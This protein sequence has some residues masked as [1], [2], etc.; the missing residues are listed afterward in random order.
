MSRFTSVCLASSNNRY[1][2]YSETVFTSR[3][4]FTPGRARPNK[5]KPASLQYP[6]RQQPLNKIRV[7][8]YSIISGVYMCC[9]LLRVLDMCGAERH[10]IAQVRNYA[11]TNPKR[12]RLLHMHALNLTWEPMDC[13]P[14]EISELIER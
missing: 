14:T 7:V 10:S 3:V 1:H 12:G 2:F 11:D 6:S 13:S 4:I 5:E 8:R 9:H